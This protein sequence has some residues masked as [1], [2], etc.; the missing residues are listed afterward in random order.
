MWHCGDAQDVCE[1]C[2]EAFSLV[3]DELQDAI[4]THIMKETPGQGF[5]EPGGGGAPILGDLAI[6][7]CP[8]LPRVTTYHIKR[9]YVKNL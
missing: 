6:M 7:L 4:A 8:H 3:S 9:L 2:R 5:C 1:I